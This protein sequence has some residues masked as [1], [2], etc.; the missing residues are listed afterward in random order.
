MLSH[1][2]IPLQSYFLLSKKMAVFLSLSLLPLLLPLKVSLCSAFF[3]WFSHFFSS[4]ISSNT[5]YFS[6]SPSALFFLQLH[7][8]RKNSVFIFFSIILTWYYQ[9]AATAR[10]LC[11]PRCFN[12]GWCWCR[13][14]IVYWVRR[15]GGWR[16]MW[17]WRGSFFLF[18]FPRGQIP[19]LFMQKRSHYTGI[20]KSLWK[21]CR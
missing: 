17:D 20:P 7:S 15:E 6:S 21:Y 11:A 8:S 10:E 16:E 18:L 2:C 1:G 13:C 5:P 3:F 14:C 4:N 19:L 12:S 9:T